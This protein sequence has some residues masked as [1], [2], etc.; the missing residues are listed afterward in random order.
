[1]TDVGG[2]LPGRFRFQIGSE[3]A[4]PFGRYRCV[5]PGLSG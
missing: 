1:M 4:D 3:D 2:P 5:N